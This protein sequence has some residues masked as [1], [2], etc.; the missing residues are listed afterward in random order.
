MSEALENDLNAVLQVT[1]TVQVGS[2]FLHRFKCP[3]C[4]EERFAGFPFKRCR[5]CNQDYS[6]FLIEF[7]ERIRLVTGT[8]RDRCVKSKKIFNNLFK[9]QEGRCA[10]CGCDLKRI[11]HHIDHVFPLSAGGGNDMNNLVISCERCNLIAGPKCF[12][13][14]SAKQK[15]ILDRRHK[16]G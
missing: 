1:E 16:I 5:T 14:F 9:L 3:G 12:N 8:F 10:Y 4:N 13:T 6:P 2:V 11:E 7:A 15:H